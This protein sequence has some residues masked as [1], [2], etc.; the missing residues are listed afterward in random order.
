MPSVLP[1]Q[2]GAERGLPA[3]FAHAPVFERHVAQRG[4]DQRPGEFGRRIRR[5]LARSHDH[6]AARTGFQIDVAAG[7]PGLGDQFQMRQ[8]L[9]QFGRDA[10]ALADEHQAI[11]L[12]EAL[13][14]FVDPGDGVTVDGHLVSGHIR[15]A[16][17]AAHRVLV[18]IRNDDFHEIPDLDIRPSKN[19]A[20]Y[21]DAARHRVIPLT[22][23]TR[24][25]C[26]SLFAKFMFMG[27]NP[28]PVEPYSRHAG[29]SARHRQ[30][31]ARNSRR[32]RE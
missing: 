15:E 22:A 16:R 19:G 1:P 7:A 2:R 26:F 24:G 25:R 9:E 8:V 30:L 32:S 28:A 27:E 13:R 11:G 18:V 6:P 5:A 29:T 23:A 12:R 20:L 21:I 14:Q 3:A 17:E 31:Q 4:E 10:G